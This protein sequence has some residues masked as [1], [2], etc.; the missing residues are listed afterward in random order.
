MLAILVL[1]VISA[2]LAWR[3]LTRRS[4]DQIRGKKNLWRAFITINPGNSLVY[5]VAGRC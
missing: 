4:D 1:E 2:A 5:W 3:D